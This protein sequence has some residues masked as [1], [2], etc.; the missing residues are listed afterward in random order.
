MSNI[1]EI[2][3]NFKVETEI[4]RDGVEFYNIDN[5]PFAIYGIYRDG[6]CYRRM[7]EEIAKN[8]SN[9]VHKL[10]A[11]TAGGRVRF[12]TDS[13]NIYIMAKMGR[14][15]KMPHFA[16]TG[17]AGFD[18]YE[19]IDSNYNYIKTINNY[20]TNLNQR[21]IVL[22]FRKI[23]CYNSNKDRKWNKWRNYYFQHTH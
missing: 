7:P 11:D 20:L 17:S 8:V 10:H 18:L 21:A 1:A 5:P 9:G 3:K 23:C 15:G 22:A 2:D 14:V 16:F 6:V 4:K 12:K 19:K 13:R